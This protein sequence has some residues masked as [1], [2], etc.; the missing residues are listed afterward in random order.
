[1]TE[2]EDIEIETKEFLS[3]LTDKELIDILVEP[4]KWE[5]IEVSFASNLLKNRGYNLDKLNIKEMSEHAR[6]KSKSKEP[7]NGCVGFFKIFLK[8]IK[9]ARMV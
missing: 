4:D 7:L 8:I 5:K 6:N 1:M 3:N 9:F 2:I